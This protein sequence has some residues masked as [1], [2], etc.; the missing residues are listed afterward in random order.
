MLRVA[1]RSPSSSSYAYAY[2]S[3]AVI[4]SD[5]VSVLSFSLCFCLS[6]PHHSHPLFFFFRFV[7]FTHHLAFLM[8]NNNL[9]NTE[10]GMTTKEQYIHRLGRTARAGKSGSG[11]LVVA[12]F[13]QAK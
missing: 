8:L 3:A 13:E 4:S 9:L 11:L 12:D 6:H 10:V 5:C 1:E 7:L 2:V